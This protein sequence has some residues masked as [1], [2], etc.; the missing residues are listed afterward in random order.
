MREFSTVAGGVLAVAAGLEADRVD[1]AV[2]LRDPEELF[3]LVPGVAGGD[4]T[5]SQPKEQAWARRSSFMSPTMTTAAPRSCAT[6]GGE[7][8]GAGAGDVDGGADPDPD[9]DADAD[10]DGAVEA[11]GEDVREHGQVHDLLQGLVPV[12]EPQQ[13]PVR[14]GHEHV[15]GLA[16]DPA[17]DVHAPVGGPGAVGVD[18][19]ADP[20]LALPCSSG[21]GRRRC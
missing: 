21:T 19:Q 20:G 7:P 6:G 5:V 9:P 15:L 4:V 18:V 16:A 12:R 10:G 17:A 1:P 3:D 11:G 14:V 2:H 8:D 13:V